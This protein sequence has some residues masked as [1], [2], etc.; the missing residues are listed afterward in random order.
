MRDNSLI[1]SEQ[2][3]SIQGEGHTTGVPAYFLRL[4][5]CNLLCKSK[6]WICDSI[7]VWKKGSSKTFDQVID[8]FG[9]E[10]INNISQQSA[11]LVITGGEPLIHQNSVSEFLDYLFELTGFRVIVEIETNGTIAP[12]D[13]LL[14]QVD[15]WNVSP[16]LSNSGELFGERYV[17]NSL[18]KFVDMSRTD[19]RQVMFK[20]VVSNEDDVFEMQSYF[21]KQLQINQRNIYL[22]PAADSRDNLQQVSESIAELCKQYGYRYSH[23]LHLTI[24]DKK[25]GV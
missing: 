3:Y 7:E 22:M 16:K 8:D 18:S 12:K 15:Y 4:A 1:V 11:H 14:K 2:F 19:G 20:F 6:T 24:W 21:V 25:T 13:K 5:G 9:S 17:R 23:R 10:F